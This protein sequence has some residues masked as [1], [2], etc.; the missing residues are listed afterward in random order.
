MDA[1]WKRGHEFAEIAE[2]CR[3]Q[4]DHIL[5]ALSRDGRLFVIY[6]AGDG[7][8]FGELY[9]VWLKRDSDRILRRDS[10]PREHPGLYQ[11]TWDKLDDLLREVEEREGL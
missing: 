8:E 3:V 9:S 11:K 5:G 10:V 4:T 6:N 1:E 7:D 2:A